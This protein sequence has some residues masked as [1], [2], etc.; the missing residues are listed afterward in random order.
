MTYKRNFQ[1]RNKAQWE[2]FKSNTILR[3]TNP[4]NIMRLL[5]D[6]YNEECERANLRRDIRKLRKMKSELFN[7]PIVIKKKKKR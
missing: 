4:S 1:A 7:M 3:G 2:R 6:R 5:I